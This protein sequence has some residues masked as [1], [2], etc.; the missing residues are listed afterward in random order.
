M[1]FFYSFEN[2]PQDPIFGLNAILKNDTRI[3]KIDLLIG[4][5][6][7]EEN[8]TPIFDAVKKAERLI[9]EKQKD[10]NYLPIDGYSPFY[11]SLT[12]LIFT[13]EFKDHVYAAQTVGGTSALHHLG[14]I[15]SYKGKVTVAVPNPTWA[16]HHQIF[17]YLGYEVVEYPYYDMQ[18]HKFLWDKFRAFLVSQKE[19]TIVLLHASCHNPSG[20]D[21]NKDQWNEIAAICKQNKL[22]PFFDCAYQGLGQGLE[23]DIESVRIFASQLDEFFLA[24]SCSKNFGMYGERTGAL[25][26]YCKNKSTKDTLSSLFKQSIRATY[27]NPP[28]QG[29]LIVSEILNTPEL[30]KNWMQ[31]LD[32]YKQRLQEIRHKYKYA[33]EKKLGK[34]FSYVL[35]GHGLF[36]F[37]GLKPDQVVS[38]RE[39]EAI[40]LASDGRLNLSGLNAKNFDNVI[41]ALCKYL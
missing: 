26:A 10:L 4:Y 7:N 16:N 21:L 32:S 34:D 1:S 18:A 6:K 9:L 14:K 41:N 30:K 15:L 29:A 20:A 38:L 3:N 33:L 19:G 28:R 12:E 17:Q 35:K 23:A 31:E 25:F 27:S 8:I 24:Y 13:A 40:Y 39:N 2:A 11:S 22:F 37:T 5:Y 36:V